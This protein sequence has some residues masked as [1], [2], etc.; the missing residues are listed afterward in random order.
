MSKTFQK[1]S[2]Y[3]LQWPP[4]FPKTTARSSAR[5]KATL[6]QALEN[7]QKALAALAKDSKKPITEVIISSNHSLTDQ[8]PKEPGVS[9]WF[10]WD[11]EQC[12]LPVDYYSEVAH[13]LQAIYHCLEA[14]RTKLRHGGLPMVR[15]AYQRLALPAPGQASVASWREVLGTDANT[16]SAVRAQYKKLASRLHPDKPTGDPAEFARVTEAYEMALA[17]IGGLDDE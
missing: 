7:V 12:C 17:E 5:F 3:P 6:Y 8:R 11:G 4:G 13:N 14:D 15:A 2:A 16:R 1:I 10:L 9:V